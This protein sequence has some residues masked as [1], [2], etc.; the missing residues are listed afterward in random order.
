MQAF[1]ADACRRAGRGSSAGVLV[2]DFMKACEFVNPQWIL[3][4]LRARQAPLWL[5][6]YVQYTLFGRIVTPKIRNRILPGLFVLTGV[7]MGSAMSPLLFCLALDP[8]L[9]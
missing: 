6:I 8:L 7:D 2:T 1:L 9:H 5:Y 4:V 3:A